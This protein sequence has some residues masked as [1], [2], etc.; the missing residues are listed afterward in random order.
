M[1]VAARRCRNIA[2][3]NKGWVSGTGLPEHG[4]VG[5]HPPRQPLRDTQRPLMQQ[6]SRLRERLHASSQKKIE[7]PQLRRTSG[8]APVVPQ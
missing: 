1:M 8:T 2:A 4:G 3:L 5:S 6:L 7:L